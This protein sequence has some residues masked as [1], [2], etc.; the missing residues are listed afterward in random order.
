MRVYHVDVYL[1]I[2][3]YIYI[4]MSCVYIY[5]YIH[6]IEGSYNIV[7][8]VDDVTAQFNAV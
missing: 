3:I 6:Q 2:Y 8:A 7:S 4:Y 5:I 1:Y